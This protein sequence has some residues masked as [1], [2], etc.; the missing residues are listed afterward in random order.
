MSHCLHLSWSV[1]TY[2]AVEF[3]IYQAHCFKGILGIAWT[4][5]FVRDG[6]LT[7]GGG[8]HGGG[9]CVS[10]KL[11][12]LA[13]WN[14]IVRRCRPAYNVNCCTQ[15]FVTDN[16]DLVWTCLFL[17]LRKCLI[18]LGF[19]PG[20]NARKEKKEKPGF[21]CSPTKFGHQAHK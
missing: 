11:V 6:F 3:K 21:S 2:T 7:R 15:R 20:N 8:H 14:L 13:C 4:F 5:T 19:S 9:R 10:W 1:P 12:N 18:C 16:E 17:I